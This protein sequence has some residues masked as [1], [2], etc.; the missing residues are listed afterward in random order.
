MK[1]LKRLTAILLSIAMLT[2]LFIMPAAAE[3]AQIELNRPSITVTKAQGDTVSEMTL[4]F[5]P[6]WMGA[7]NAMSLDCADFGKKLTFFVDMNAVRIAEFLLQPT[8]YDA[9]T[10]VLTVSVLN[11]DGR[12]GAPLYDVGYIKNHILH[13]IYT[14]S[15]S[16]PEGL[17]YNSV[18]RSVN[19]QKYIEGTKHNDRDKLA[20]ID[21]M[22]QRMSY[23]LEMPDGARR[24]CHWI[25]SLPDTLFSFYM[26]RIFAFFVMRI[27][28]IPLEP[29]F[30]RDVSD[31]LKAYGYDLDRELF[32]NPKDVFNLLDYI[33]YE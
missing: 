4:D 20:S 18:D 11:K 30:R 6:A 26:S 32:R 17:L 22:P 5:T 31:S 16:I 1:S 12:I 33:M 21:G 24:I 14:Y 25:S 28:L 23:D 8:A 2:T 9:E 29:R 15:L 27:I 19:A 13:S 7:E 10:G 3:D